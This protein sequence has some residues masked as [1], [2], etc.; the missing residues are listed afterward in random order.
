MLVVTTVIQSNLK[1]QMEKK[2]DLFNI[3]LFYIYKREYEKLYQREKKKD[4]GLGKSQVKTNLSMFESMKKSTSTV[5]S[6]F[7]KHTN[8]I[9]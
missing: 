2:G 4:N 9:L 8:P 3:C 6:E 5:G 7:E 1:L